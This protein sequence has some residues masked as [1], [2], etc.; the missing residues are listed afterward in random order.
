MN[1][2]K[3][4]S[5]PSVETAVDELQGGSKARIT[6]SYRRNNVAKTVVRKKLNFAC[7]CDKN[8]CETFLEPLLTSSS[9]QASMPSSSSLHDYLNNN[10]IIIILIILIIIIVNIFRAKTKGFWVRPSLH[11]FLLSNVSRAICPLLTLSQ[12]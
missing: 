11:L 12:T 5:R 1:L 8:F 9:L 7:R 4:T 3:P 6:Q 2:W 10:I